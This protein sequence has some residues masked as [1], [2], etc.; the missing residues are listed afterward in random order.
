MND[1]T[2]YAI[3]PDRKSIA[4]VQREIRF[5]PTDNASPKVLSPD[6]I[7][8]WNRDGYLGPLTVLGDSDTQ[9]LREYFDDLLAQ[10]FAAGKDSY[11]IS[12]AHLK[13][14]R[15]WDLLTNPKIVSYVADLLGENVIGWGSHFFCKMPGDGKRVDW[16]QDCSYWP[17][18]PTKAVTVWLAI[19]DADLD[20]GGM[21][22]YTGSHRHGLIDFDT[23]EEDSGNVLDQVVTQPEKYGAHRFTPIAAGQIS[24]HSDLL[25]H[26]SAP[27]QSDRRRC[28][29][30]LRYCPADVTAYLNWERKGVVVAGTAPKDRW[31]G[32]VR[33]F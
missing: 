2:D 17:L 26:G 13:H 27:N 11:S 10:T 4:T 22:V 28:G 18:T 29:L 30:T 8:A 6:Q 12:S 20:N 24:I 21:E 23:T 31:P 3:I 25:V 9:E 16:H 14:A 15:V 7:D 19:D 33:P 5:F 32:A 1:A